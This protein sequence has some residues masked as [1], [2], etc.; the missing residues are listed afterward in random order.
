MSEETPI[1]T[2]AETPAPAPEAEAPQPEAPPQEPA[3]ISM[4]QTVQ[5]NGETMTVKQLADAADEAK[6]LREYQRAA[7]GILRNTDAELT[8][9]RESDVRYVMAYEGYTDEQINNYIDSL[10]QPVGAEGQYQE[11]PQVAE[12]P[13]VNE[14]SSRMEALEQREKEAR[15]EQLQNKLAAAVQNATN[16]Q[17]LQNLGSAFKRIHGDEGAQERASV[18]QEDIHRETVNHLRRLKTQGG[19]IDDA[20]IQQASMSAAETVAK[21]YRTVIGDPDKIGRA[22]ETASGQDLFFKKK[23]IEVPQ[24]KPGQDTTA[25]VY[26]KAK[27]FAEDT[28]LDMAADISQGGDS[29]L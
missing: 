6:Y 7:S 14:M 26:E 1:E 15:V 5:V 2:P 9:E 23:P 11:A 8:E 24:F 13:R 28:L 18:L 10:K 3:S 21:R 20:S 17:D 19:N 12:D 27:S 22:P 29:K 25:S 16:I 4:D